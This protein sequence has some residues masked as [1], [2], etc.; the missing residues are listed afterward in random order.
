MKTAYKLFLTILMVVGISFTASAQ[1]NIWS[2]NN[3]SPDTLIKGQGVARASFPREFKLFDLNIEPFRQQVFSI[4]D[5]KTHASTVISLP[6]AAGFIER[7]EIFEDSNFDPVLQARFPDIRAYSGRGITDPYATLKLSISPQGIQ[8]MV[9]RTDQENEYMEPFTQDRTVYAVFSA[10]REKGGSPWSC[11]TEER[12]LISDLNS[13]ILNAER[14]ESSAGQVKTISL[15]TVLQ[16]RVCQ[17]LRCVQLFAGGL[18]FSGVQRNY[19]AA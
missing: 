14:P 12:N 3:D 9:F 7:F 15:G 16:W 10:H 19:H 17:L 13:Q 11:S 18:G 5:S 4:V 2:V 6:N 8:T 1:E